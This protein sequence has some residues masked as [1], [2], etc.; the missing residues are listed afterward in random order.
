MSKKS[1]F[2][3]NPDFW[4]EKWQEARSSSDFMKKRIRSEEET[5]EFW[6]QF[7]PRYNKRS[8]PG[9]GKDRVK[10]VVD[11][12]K[13]KNIINSETSVLDVGSGPGNYAL[14]FAKICREV[15]ALDSAGEMINQL[16]E[17]AKKENL[18]NIKTLHRRWE[19]IDIEKEKM[20]GSFDL[21]FASLAPAIFDSETL[22]KM[23]LASG[24]YCCL[25]SWA[26]EAHSQA[27][28]DLWKII[29]NESYGGNGQN[30]I[31]PFNL[32]FSMGY[33]PSI[34]YFDSD[35]NYSD[36][37]DEAVERLISTF[38]LFTEITDDIRK[39]IRDYVKERAVDNIFT[40]NTEVKLGI[41]TWDVNEKIN[42]G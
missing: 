20:N 38:W 31:Y 16:A 42:R 40:Q 27:R 32:L 28:R 5:T 25:I 13:E 36:P 8:K 24:K 22:N 14:P 30:I 34:R 23:N 7:A 11:L 37:V 33:F 29:F 3:N 10:M 6:N 1:D 12:F 21:V 18:T 4:K 9:K 35:H 26:S 19:D 15:T 2:I 17:K 41:V 39:T